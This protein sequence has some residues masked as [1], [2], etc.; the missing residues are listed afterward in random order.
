[1]ADDIDPRFEAR[2][3][4]AFRH[5][6]ED[7]PLG[8][9]ED[10]VLAR[11]RTRRIRRLA[12][13]ASLLA[14][15]AVITLVVVAGLPRIIAQNRVAAAP[16]APAAPTLATYDELAAM[17]PAGASAT[18]VRGEHL[19]DEASPGDTTVDL[20]EVGAGSPVWY[21]L[22]CFGASVVT[23]F[24]TGD[25]TPDSLSL[26]C[27]TGPVSG[28][29]DWVVGPANVT[30]SAP[31]T[32]TW[33]LVLAPGTG[34]ARKLETYE[35]LRH[36]AQ[37]ARTTGGVSIA[38]GEGPDPKA[39]DLILTTDLGA[40]GA[41]RDIQLAFDCIGG[42]IE[43]RVVSGDTVIEGYKGAC[44][45]AVDIEDIALDASD[46]QARLVVVASRGVAWRL[47]AVGPMPDV[48]AAP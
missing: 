34:P 20:G 38:K 18:A 14:G 31:S 48:T 46:S 17:L 10:A 44:K 41:V 37:R 6:V 4:A 26:G 15:A 45:P 23:T 22:S 40:I 8:V 43:V 5:E 2:L 3:R 9:E 39:D 11:W 25:T 30:V 35:E 32:L 28:S 47:L 7:R 16:S 24:D 36:A 21:A 27:G 13:P 29:L 12:I 42:D 33:R 1:M 19:G